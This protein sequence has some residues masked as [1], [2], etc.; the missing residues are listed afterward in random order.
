MHHLLTWIVVLPLIGF[1]IN[2]ALSLRGTGNATVNRIVTV[3]GCGLPAIAFALAVQTF[4]D[5]RAA[6]YAPIIDVAYTWASIAGQSFEVG[7]YFDRLATVMAL[8]VTGVGSLIHVYSVGYMKDDPGYGRFFAYLNL[9]LF[10]MLLLVL[11]RSMLVLFVGW[12]GVGLA[13][14]LLIGFWFDDLGNARA[15]KKAFITNRVGDAA[16]LLGMFL[17]YQGLGTLDM[18]R[19]NAAF[20][21]AVMPAVSAS[22]V[23]LLLF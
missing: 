18:D 10:F 9:F 15:G 16:F 13:S 11:G 4:V 23:G 5:L 3:V 6:A 19:I 12:E 7:F 1:V 21:A 20:G 2:G 17:L 8:V 22:L 14:Y